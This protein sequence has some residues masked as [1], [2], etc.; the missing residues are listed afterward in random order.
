MTVSGRG[1]DCVV[2]GAD[3]AGLVLALLLARHGRRVTVLDRGPEHRRR[4][5]GISPFLSPAALAVLRRLGLSDALLAAGRPVRRV[6]EHPRHGRP[7]VLAYDRAPDT[8]FPFALSVPQLTLQHLLHTALRAQPTARV[9]PDT[10]PLADVTETRGGQVRLHRRHGAPITARAVVCADG[11]FSRTRRLAGIEAD[12][13][14]VDRPVAMVH[15][16][17]PAHWPD[18]ITAHH[19][20]GDGLVTT[21]PLAGDRLIVQCL[22]AADALRRLRTQPVDRL[23]GRLTAVLPEL[24]DPLARQVTSWDRVS[25][26]QHHVVRPRAWTRG[27]LVLLGDAAHG[28]HSFAGQGLSLAVQDAVVLAARLLDAGPG[29]VPAALCGY[30]RARRPFTERFQTYQLSLPQLTSTPVT[31]PRR[32]PVYAPL[33]DVMVTGQPEVHALLP[34]LV[35]ATPPR[36]TGDAAH[37]GPA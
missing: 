9:E 6:V 7:Y 28:V 32:F 30:E 19:V 8:P 23:L 31:P 24:H 20:D 21:I 35:P 16:P 22:V 1:V 26:V 14:A 36:V 18:Q 34:R 3:P 10:L 4:L 2:V 17:L 33:A 15:L 29:T 11:P 27:N 13:T 25:L 12:V 5:A 37:T